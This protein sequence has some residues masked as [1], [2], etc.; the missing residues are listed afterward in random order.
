MKNKKYRL[1]TSKELGNILQ[2]G[3]K[4]E[5]YPPYMEIQL[6]YDELKN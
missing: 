6:E 3:A 1:L 2:L 5:K 4:F